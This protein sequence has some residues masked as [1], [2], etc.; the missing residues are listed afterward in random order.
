MMK[1]QPPPQTNLFHFV[2]NIDKRIRADHELR[3]VKE[4]IDFDFVFAEVRDFYGYNGKES[5]PPPVI[6]KLMLLLVMYNVRSELE[7][8]QTI[9]ERLDW[10]WYVF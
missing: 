1:V 3:K 8:M 6:L 5:V 2:V 10:L 7:L 4:L 9:P